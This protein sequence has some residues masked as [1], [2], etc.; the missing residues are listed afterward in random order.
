MNGTSISAAER[1]FRRPEPS[2]RVMRVARSDPGGVRL[3][4]GTALVVCVLVLWH[5]VRLVIAL[6]Y[7]PGGRMPWLAWLVLALGAGGIAAALRLGSGRTPRL[8]FGFAAALAAVVVALDLVA[9]HGQAGAGVTPT[10]AP[11]AIALLAPFTWLVARR[12]PAACALVFAAV[13]A[14]VC[15]ASSPD[16]AH[17]SARL[18][19]IAGSGALPVVLAAVASGG[20][21]RMVEQQLDL[22]IVQSTVATNRQAVGMRASE[23]L[24][25]LDF[26]A[27]TL[28]EGVASG[29]LTLPLAPETAEE[30]ASLAAALRVRLIEG[31]TDTWLKHAVAESEFLT[32]AVRVVDPRGDAGRLAPA[33]R[34]ALLQAVWLI[35]GDLPRQAAGPVELALGADV[36]QTGDENTPGPVVNVTI[37]APSQL[38]RRLDAATWDAIGSV[39]PHELRVDAESIRIDIA[40]RITVGEPADGASPRTVPRETRGIQ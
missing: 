27:E 16:A 4:G 18:I 3:A 20:F 38:K 26:E 39:G 10:A 2:E 17:A 22:S 40:C 31:R 1:G 35:V 34:D 19:A 30:A 24:A 8:L 28:L 29:R 7:F 5:L 23:E 9:T 25:S 12:A 36:P 33:A 32:G 6:P 13:L 15:L 11:A 14:G 21:R 37:R